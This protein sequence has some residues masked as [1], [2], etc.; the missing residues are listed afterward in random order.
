M[1]FNLHSAPPDEA[2]RLA[3]RSSSIA[4]GV[5]IVANR[6]RR[7]L[8]RGPLSHALCHRRLDCS[9]GLLH[10]KPPVCSEQQWDQVMVQLFVDLSRATATPVVRLEQACVGYEAAPSI[11]GLHQQTLRALRREYCA[12][13]K[14][15]AILKLDAGDLGGA[16]RSTGGFPRGRAFAGD[17]G[18]P[19][20]LLAASRRA[21]AHTPRI[22]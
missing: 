3:L 19:H 21:S 7:H 11:V 9:E 4:A 14:L 5:F 18:Y 2:A 22:S 8:Y 17:F 13:S 1:H 16:I 15:T 10:S 20:P 12:T 6:Y